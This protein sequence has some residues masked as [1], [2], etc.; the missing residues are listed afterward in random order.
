[1]S[2]FE[3]KAIELNAEEMN[4]I[5]G[6]GRYDKLPPK[7]GFVIYQVQTGDTLSKIAHKFGCTVNN[8]LAWNP[9][10]TNKNTIYAGEY[11]YIKA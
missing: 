8:I 3:N 4:S 7:S 6:G 11:L 2:E 5:V 1:M 10:I 9:K